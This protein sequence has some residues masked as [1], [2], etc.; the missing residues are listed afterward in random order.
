MLYVATGRLSFVVVGLVAFA[1]GAWYLGAH[2]PHIH[3]RVEAW[4]HPF[5]PRLYNKLGWAATR[6]PTPCSP[7]RPAGCSARASAR[8]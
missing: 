5:S 6:S 3:A 8:R 2:I 7:R 1:I 4:L